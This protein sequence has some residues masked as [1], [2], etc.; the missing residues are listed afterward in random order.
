MESSYSS[1]SDDSMPFT[2]DVYTTPGAIDI[3][4]SQPAFDPFDDFSPSG[5]FNSQGFPDVY[6]FNVP[7]T[8]A[9]PPSSPFDTTSLQW[10]LNWDEIPLPNYLGTSGSPPEL[11]K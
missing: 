6:P 10:P 4:R 11:P 2:S 3:P 5:S 8:V 7:Y 1:S 9:V